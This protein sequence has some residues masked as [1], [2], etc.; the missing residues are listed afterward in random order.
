MRR[1]AAPS[2]RTTDR[3][4]KGWQVGPAHAFC[5]RVFIITT[6]RTTYTTYSNDCSSSTA[7]AVPQAWNRTAVRRTAVVRAAQT[8]VSSC[9]IPRVYLVVDMGRGGVG[10]RWC[11]AVGLRSVAVVF[12]FVGWPSLIFCAPATTMNSCVEMYGNPT[13]AGIYEQHCCQPVGAHATSRTT[14][15][16]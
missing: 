15:V 7:V 2:L 3:C 1:P 13:S 8:P 5:A 12:A 16:V 6:P 14:A 4:R 10:R 11:T 9:I